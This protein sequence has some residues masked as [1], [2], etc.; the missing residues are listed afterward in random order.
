[1]VDGSEDTKEE[2]PAESESEGV[3]SGNLVYTMA[4][5]DFDAGQ[6]FLIFIEKD[7][8]NKFVFTST[9]LGLGDQE[10]NEFY[11]LVMPDGAMM[12]VI[13]EN[14]NASFQPYDFTYEIEGQTPDGVTQYSPK[15]FKRMD[16]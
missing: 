14:R 5:M 12:P 8:E 1:M 3:K 9:D 4:Y 13:V 15:E 10:E 2:A 16:K 7:T 11:K 6:I